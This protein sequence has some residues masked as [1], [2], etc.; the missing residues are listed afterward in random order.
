MYQIGNRAVYTHDIFNTTLDD[1]TPAKKYRVISLQTLLNSPEYKLKIQGKA[2][3]SFW[4][5]DEEEKEHLPSLKPKGLT[6]L[7]G[8]KALVLM[9]DDP[10]PVSTQLPPSPTHGVPL[11]TPDP[12]NP[13]HPDHSD[14]PSH[15]YPYKN[16]NHLHRHG[17][18][19]NHHN[20]HNHPHGP[21]NGGGGGGDD[22]HK[23]PKH[24]LRR[25]EIFVNGKAR[26]VHGHENW[27]AG[28]GVIHVT[29]KILMPPRRKGCHM[30]SA[31]ECSVWETLWDLASTDLESIMED[32]TDY[33]N[34]LTLFDEEHSEDQGNTFWDGEVRWSDAE[35]TYNDEEVEE[36]I[37]GWD[38]YW[39]PIIMA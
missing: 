2:R 6:D 15:H 16:P 23:M 3:K 25:D 5:E 18:H 39:T 20:H 22:D 37:Q 32:V 38:E 27:I 35:D 14:R 36:Q 29:D 31:L 34:D 33:F 11:P 7:I 19:H 4:D 12:G 17:K 9:K 13:D 30:M 24:A 10:T 26:V 8:W 28:N 1:G 21:R